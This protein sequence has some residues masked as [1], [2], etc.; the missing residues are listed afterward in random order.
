MLARV[1]RRLFANSSSLHPV[2]CLSIAQSVYSLPSVGMRQDLFLHSDRLELAEVRIRIASAMAGLN[3]IWRCNTISF[4]SN[5]KLYK[6]LVTCIL[7]NGCETWT[8]LADFEK[9]KRIQ[10]FKTKCMR[11]L[12]GISY[13]DQRL[14]AKGDVLPCR[15]TDT[16]LE[17]VK[18]RKLAWFGHVTRHELWRVG[19]AV[20]SRGNARWTTSKNGH[21]CPCQN[22][23]QRPPAEEIGRGSLLNRLSYLKTFLKMG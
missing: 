15:S 2:V 20:V 6:S 23:S 11:K 5:F 8:L 10:A 9:K 12:H 22:S 4:A 21:P 1:S 14:D 13:Q 3:R 18:R 17:T 16:F 19:D 7:L